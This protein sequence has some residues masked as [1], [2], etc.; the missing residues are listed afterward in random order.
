MLDI[1]GEKY[2]NH[3]VYKMKGNILLEYEKRKK[4]GEGKRQ[5]RVEMVREKCIIQKTEIKSRKKQNDI[6]VK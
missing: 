3:K 1:F 2:G 4:K 6:D 5:T